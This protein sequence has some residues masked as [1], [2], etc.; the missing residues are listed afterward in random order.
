MQSFKAFPNNG[1]KYYPPYGRNLP[2]EC[3]CIEWDDFGT[4][5]L[6]NF[7]FVAPVAGVYEFM[8]NL[9]WAQPP[10]GGGLSCLLMKN[11]LGSAGGDPGGECGGTDITAFN[12]SGTSYISTCVTQSVK[13]AA[14][15]KMW[16][17]PSNGLGASITASVYPPNGNTITNYF[18][19]KQLR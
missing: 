13:M 9:L 4:F 6:V 7:C 5:D 3:N 16:A 11:L 1:G 12:P 18:T 8:V 19:G 15:D 17:V 14:G 2:L 10:H